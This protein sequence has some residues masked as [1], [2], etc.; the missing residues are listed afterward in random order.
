MAEKWQKRSSPPSSGGPG[1]RLVDF[2]GFSS[3]SLYVPEI[4]LLVYYSWCCVPGFAFVDGIH[5]SMEK[6]ETINGLLRDHIFGQVVVAKGQKYLLQ[7]DGIAQVIALI[8][9][10]QVK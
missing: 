9:L 6:K 7:R 10:R 8:F 1:G 3:S 4:I 5:C 2:L